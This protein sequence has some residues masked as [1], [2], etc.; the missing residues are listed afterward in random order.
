MKILSFLIV[1][2]L[3]LQ[4]LV[5]TKLVKTTEVQNNFIKDIA[6][7]MTKVNISREESLKKDLPAPTEVQ[8]LPRFAP[9]MDFVELL[10]EMTD[11]RP[12]EKPKDYKCCTSMRAGAGPDT[13]IN[14]STGFTEDVSLK[15]FPFIKEGE[16]RIGTVN[17]SLDGTPTNQVLDTVLKPVPWNIFVMGPNVHLVYDIFL[18]S[19][20]NW[21]DYRDFGEYLENKK[22]AKHLTA[23]DS[24]EI[25]CRSQW[26]EVRLPAAGNKK[27]QPF[28][29]GVYKEY[30]NRS[31]T[32]LVWIIFDKPDRNLL[33]CVINSENYTKE[34]EMYMKED[35]PFV[36]L[37]F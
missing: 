12:N 26:Y 17:I 20:F 9:H 27:H 18:T 4:V 34:E 14:W 15:F 6:T 13:K 19:D 33:R 32:V 24:N 23:L 25:N 37:Y 30:G 2:V 16:G 35:K 5:F 28:W 31:G 7:E 10:E 36:K 21:E 11:R 1:M 22:W 3:C 29:M 8:V